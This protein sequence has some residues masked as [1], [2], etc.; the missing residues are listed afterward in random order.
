MG[1]V[2]QAFAK[3]LAYH[4]ERLGWTQAKLAERID[5]SP[6]YVGHLER[7]EREPSLLTIEEL[8]KALGIEP[9]E[10]FVRRSAGDARG[11]AHDELEELLRPRTADDL[12]M[13]IRLVRAAL[14]HPGLR[15]QTPSAGRGPDANVRATARTSARARCKITT[16]RRP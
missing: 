7:G 15:N 5:S 4:R 12:E 3:N 11:R 1:A 2:R 6:S 14:D 10:L 13:A 8:C 16:S 9:G